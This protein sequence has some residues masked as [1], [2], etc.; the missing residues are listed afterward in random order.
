MSVQLPPNSSGTVLQTHLPTIGAAT[1][2]PTFNAGEVQG[3]ALDFN[4]G[5]PTYSAAYLAQ[6]AGTSATT[7][8]FILGGSAT[9]VVRLL[10]LAITITTATAGV[11]YDV[12]LVKESALPTGGTAATAATIAPWDSG[13]AAATAITR[14]YTA[15]PTTGTQIG[16]LFT[17]KYFSFISPATTVL[18]PKDSIIWTPP[19]GAAA[20]A[21]RGAA[22]CFSVTINAG[23]PANATSWD[24][25][26]VWTE[27]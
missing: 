19:V 25:S 13:F 11:A 14:F 8:I 16:T 7:D 4:N 9:K 23:T 1:G 15:T 17:Y 27:E 6:S 3:V 5:K 20:P 22:Q 24:V 18:P 10:Q 12:M 26:C 2:A 21:L